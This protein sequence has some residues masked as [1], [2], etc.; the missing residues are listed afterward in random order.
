MNMTR[1]FRK[2][3]KIIPVLFFIFLI[4]LIPQQIFAEDLMRDF[5]DFINLVKNFDEEGF[6]KKQEALEKSNNVKGVYLTAF[7]AGS[8]HLEA[9]RLRNDIKKLLKETELTAVVIDVKEVEGP[10]FSESL[11]LFIEELHQNNIW[12]IARIVAF[13]DFSLIKRN[14]EWYL[15]TKKGDLWQDEAGYYWLD[16]ACPEA[17]NYLLEISKKAIDFSFD[18][19]QFDYLRFPDRGDLENIVYPFSGIERGKNKII[20]DF[21]LKLCNDLRNYKTD[22]IL[23]IDLFGLIAQNFNIPGIGQNLADT[24]GFFDYVSPMLYPSHYF[25]G[26]AVT[27]DSKRG[28]SPLYFPYIDEDIEKVVSNHPYEVVSRSIFQISDYIRAK[29]EYMVQ[30]SQ[31]RPGSYIALLKPNTTR[32]IL[33]ASGHSVFSLLKNFFDRYVLFL[34]S[35]DPVRCSLSN[36]AGRVDTKIRP[37]L[38]DFDLKFDKDRGI[39]YDE[40]KIR[41]Q[42]NAAESSGA[43]GWLL[44]NSSNIYTKEALKLITDN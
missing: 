40:N 22:I 43:S 5:K 1:N 18:E 36:G 4:S 44:W 34:D 23:S 8:R 27:S 35:L 10:S 14:P 9:E 26:F 20:N 13:R 28:L 6:L 21:Y 2:I 19:I 25:Q 31:A 41:A 7:T 37:W 17:Q 32:N 30:A 38:Q 11:R 29:R 12:V 33:A 16:P 39:Y 3:K 42:I 15:K 24:T